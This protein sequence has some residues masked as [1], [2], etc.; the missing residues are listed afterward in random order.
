MDSREKPSERLLSQRIR[1]RM[2][3]AV[4][5]LAE[6]DDVVRVVGDVSYFYEF[7]DFIDD[8]F[9]PRWREHTTLTEP[10]VVALD[11][12]LTAMEEALDAAGH[13]DVEPFIASG[14]PRRIQPIAQEAL[15]LLLSRGRFDEEVEEDEPSG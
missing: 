1:N 15:A 2:I 14:W 5:M 7:F 4:E 9:V 10:E 11:R 13:L 12:V 3:G 8:D 6:G